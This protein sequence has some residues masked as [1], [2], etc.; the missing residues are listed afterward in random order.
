MTVQ[1]SVAQSAAVTGGS[2]RPTSFTR[3]PSHRSRKVLRR[4]EQFLG[5]E[6]R[7]EHLWAAI[8]EMT[9][10]EGR[11]RRLKARLQAA[12]RALEIPRVTGFTV[13]MAS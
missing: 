7:R 3:L 13:L 5:P 8:S 11:R 1:A 9:G 4:A 6:Q 10:L 12:Q 2:C